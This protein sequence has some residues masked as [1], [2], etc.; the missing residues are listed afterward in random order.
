VDENEK[1]PTG[2]TST[3][4]QPQSEADSPITPKTA[5]DDL[6]PVNEKEDS[7]EPFYKKLRKGSAQFSA[8]PSDQTFNPPPVMPPVANTDLPTQPL[9]NTM[10]DLQE[11]P[12]K[13]LTPIKLTVLIL[14]LV[15]IGLITISATLVATDYT[16]YEPPGLIKNIL[17]KIFSGNLG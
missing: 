13:L 6:P 2:S 4:N 14:L 11:K 12:K 7:K 3:S 5:E 16:I 15:I 9:A 17:E 1:R 10:E 8:M